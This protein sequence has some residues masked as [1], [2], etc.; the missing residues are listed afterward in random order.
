MT[1]LRTLAYLIG[2]S[3]DLCN[4]EHYL[5]LVNH[6]VQPNKFCIIIHKCNVNLNLIGMR[7]LM[8]YVL[9]ARESIYDNIHFLFVNSIFQ[10]FIYEIL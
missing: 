9:G 2:A 5:V 7:R 6:L 4:I 1:F 3:Y 10:L 8:S